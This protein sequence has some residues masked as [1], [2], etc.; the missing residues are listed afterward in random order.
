MVRL[1]RSQKNKGAESAHRQKALTELDGED[2]REGA[3]SVF[4]TQ[5][6]KRV[7]FPTWERGDNFIK[8]IICVASRLPFPLGK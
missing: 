6:Q 1:V 7:L 2:Q 8:A 4:V 5:I 3:E